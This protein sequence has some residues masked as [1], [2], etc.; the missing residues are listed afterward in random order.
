MSK[1]NPYYNPKKTH[2]SKQ[3]FENPEPIKFDSSDYQR[4]RKERAAQ[5]LPK[6]PGQGY[7]AF[8][9]R[10]WQKADFSSVSDRI[11]WLGHSTLL[12]QI[13][14][15]RFLTDP[16][17]SRRVSP[18][19]F[20]G[21]QRKTEVAA[22]IAELPSI[23]AVVISHNHYDH[24]DSYSVNQLI[25]RFPEV[26]FFVPLGL[27]RW[28]VRRG[29]KQVTELDWWDN[30]VFRDSQITCVPARHWSSRTLWDR[31]RS[32]WAGW[33]IRYCDFRFYFMGDTGYT[34]QLSEISDRLGAPDLAAIP[35]GAY[36]PRWFMQQQHI[37]PFQAVQLHRELLC[38][39]SLAIHWGAF[40]LADEPLDEPP[41]K[42]EEAL[43]DLGV[44]SS[45]FQLI[46][47][48]SSIDL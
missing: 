6:V 21:P 31:N 10:W 4:W 17:F 35:I 7:T 46:K 15:V 36:Q 20:A 44:A 22:T 2:H 38:K 23:D 29:A 3:G 1:Q 12:L 42:L 27:K 33:F 43:R 18:V 32:L 41:L 5:K 14:G 25:K 11:W 37:D 30:T 45:D 19:S 28:M 9:K 16:V 34:H 47:I 13:G 39:R 8:V 48:G 26:H 40:E 24:L